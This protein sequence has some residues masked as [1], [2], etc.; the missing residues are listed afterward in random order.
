MSRQR[1]AAFNYL[2]SSIPPSLYRNG[3]VYLSRK[4]DGTD[5]DI[6]GYKED[7]RA[8]AVNDARTDAAGQYGLHVNGFELVE[9]PLPTGID[10]L[11]HEQ[12]VRQYYPACQD[13]LRGF[14]GAQHVLAF[15]HNVRWKVGE[16]EKRQTGEGQQVQKPIRMVH[17]DYT[18]TSAPQ[19]LQ[20]LA[21]PP[22][23][24]DTLKPFLKEGETVLSADLVEH[25]LSD[26]G[27]FAIINLWRNI[28]DTPI[29]RDPLA[30]CD[31]QT[32]GIDD[33]VVFELHYSDR[34][35]ENY[36]ARWSDRHEW[37]FYPEMTRD[38]VV[39]IKQWD[40]SG[41]FAATSGAE[42]DAGA[43]AP[44]SLNFHS[45]FEDPW[46]RPTAPERCSIEVRCIAVY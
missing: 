30:F 16:R 27:R 13:V 29:Q 24:N 28:A 8:T 15:D 4:P 33:L 22:R 40:S 12:V 17:G 5:D 31:S 45:S 14:T 7:S 2:A 38:E 41:H 43:S 37:Y 21:E 9:Q 20:D 18:L 44:C 6:I 35:G 46:T 19:R 42:A 23:A 11:S 3:N 26:A 36:F 34:I 10:F 25:A 39:L 32:I 1:V